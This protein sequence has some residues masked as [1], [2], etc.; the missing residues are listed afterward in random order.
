MKE[1]P[2]VIYGENCKEYCNVPSLIK[3][4]KSYGVVELKNPSCYYN[5][6]YEKCSIF[7]KEKLTEK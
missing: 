5:N 4:E 7:L 2:Y 3:K 1:C 6:D